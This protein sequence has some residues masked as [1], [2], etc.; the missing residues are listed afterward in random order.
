MIRGD[1]QAINLCKSA[2]DVLLGAKDSIPRESIL[3]KCLQVKINLW[4]GYFSLYEQREQ[5]DALDV[6]KGV[7]IFVVDGQGEAIDGIGKGI[8]EGFAAFF[9]FAGDDA[10]C[11]LAKYVVFPDRQGVF[12]GQFIINAI[13]IM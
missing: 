3:Y 7:V 4:M 10:G 8:F 1:L 2:L 5:A 9:H 6:V 13:S 11:I 12:Q